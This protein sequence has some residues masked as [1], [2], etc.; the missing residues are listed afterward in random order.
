[1]KKDCIKVCNTKQS[2]LKMSPQPTKDEDYSHFHSIV[3][4]H[5]A[6]QKKRNKE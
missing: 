2:K 3:R 6:G 4:V 5:I 1:M